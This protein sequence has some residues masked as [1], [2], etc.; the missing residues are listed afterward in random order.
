MPL[1]MPTSTRLS[2]KLSQRLR[3]SEVPQFVYSR[4]RRA[5]VKHGACF[6]YQSHFSDHRLQEQAMRRSSILH[7]CIGPCMHRRMLILKRKKV[8]TFVFLVAI[9]KPKKQ[10][11]TNYPRFPKENEKL[12]NKPASPLWRVYAEM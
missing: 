1:L 10:V 6:V 8:H 4:P 9:R 7:E 2:V 12:N 3:G 5:C 11:H